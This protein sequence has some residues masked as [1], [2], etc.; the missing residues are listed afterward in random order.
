MSQLWRSPRS[1]AGSLH[2]YTLGLCRSL[3]VYLKKIKKERSFVQDF[4]CT[5]MYAVTFAVPF[6]P[7]LLVVGCGDLV[8]TLTSVSSINNTHTHCDSDYPVYVRP[9]WYL[10]DVILLRLNVCAFGIYKPVWNVS[11]PSPPLAAV[12][13]AALQAASVKGY[14][15]RVIIMQIP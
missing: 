9:R 14:G 13:A 3:L 1:R 15:V 10:H 7:P 2:R 6:T 11:I 4:I 5:I 8:F 12:V